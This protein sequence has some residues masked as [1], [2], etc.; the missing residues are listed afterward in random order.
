M[1][2][3][4]DFRARLEAHREQNP[5]QIVR[6]S[7]VADLLDEDPELPDWCPP[8]LRTPGFLA[9]VRLFREHRHDH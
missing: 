9:E 5:W 1:P 7:M 3:E 4:A 8:D 2:V 6:L